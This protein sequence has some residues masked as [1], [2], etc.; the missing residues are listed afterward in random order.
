MSAAKSTREQKQQDA[1]KWFREAFAASF[2]L[3]TRQGSE[4]T[5]LDAVQALS[6]VELPTSKAAAKEAIVQSCRYSLRDVIDLM[7][8]VLQVAT[9][10]T[11]VAETARGNFAAHITKKRGLVYHDD[12]QGQRTKRRVPHRPVG[13]RAGA[14]R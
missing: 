1:S 14:S 12:P 4:L 2:A 9:L 7:E 3:S 10:V 8:S 6:Q 11:T 13:K 5:V